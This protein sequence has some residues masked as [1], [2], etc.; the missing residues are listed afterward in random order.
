MRVA[1]RAQPLHG[2]GLDDVEAALALDG[3]EDDRGDAR[4]LDV[5]LEQVLDGLLGLVQRHS[6]AGERDVIDLRREG[7][8]AGLVRL[9]LAGERHGEQAAPMESAAEGDH[10]RAL[11]VRARDFDGVLHRLGPGREQRGLLRKVAGRQRVELLGQRHVALV[12]HD[13]ITSVGEALQLLLDGGDDFRMAMPGIE[14]RDAPGE[15]DVATAFD[16]PEF[17]ALGAVGIK[18]G[19]HADAARRGRG[20]AGLQLFVAGMVHGGSLKIARLRPRRCASRWS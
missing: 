19:H 9:H 4:G 15:V 5:G 3:L 11:G 20:P 1:Q 12:R 8:E 6:L 16:I 17:G 7:A 18:T 13:L 10:A 14:H 2:L